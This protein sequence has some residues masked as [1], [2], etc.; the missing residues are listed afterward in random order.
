M[1]KS[2]HALYQHWKAAQ[3]RAGKF[4]G[5]ANHRCD[6]KACRLHTL[7]LFRRAN[8]ALTLNNTRQPLRRD[9]ACIAVCTRTGQPHYCGSGV[10]Q[11][12]VETPG[13]DVVC[14]LTGTVL[15]QSRVALGRYGDVES[16][17]PSTY[18][19]RQVKEMTAEVIFERA[20]QI[21]GRTKFSRPANKRE[22]LAQVLVLV[23][24]IFSKERFEAE[25]QRHHEHNAFIQGEIH[26]YISR[27]NTKQ[28]F[29]DVLHL[30][31]LVARLRQRMEYAMS[32]RL[33]EEPLK[34]LANG[35]ATLVTT[36]W[37]V[38]R[39]RAAAAGG[40]RVATVASLREFVL[41]TLETC[42]T[43]LTVCARD[44]SYEIEIVPL[45]PIMQ[46]LPMTA[47]AQE[48]VLGK[49]KNLARVRKNI[50]SALQ[51][52]I[53]E[54]GVNPEELRL[55]AY[56]FEGLDETAFSGL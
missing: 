50:K 56:E 36:L 42:Q 18:V 9:E 29:P 49:T 6:G 2:M 47:A 40:Q 19:P 34:R 35:Y 37:H 7:C 48:I 32:L 44:R 11:E 17:M 5:T 51:E 10:C 39:T 31:A 4:Y 8:G 16:T 13:G 28:E 3:D 55:V 20:V 41:A 30:A 21:S 52:A 14:R 24:S 12:T 46:I 26:K 15:T 43:G 45:D 53:D 27:C 33:Q 38:L 1:L 23:T 25:H 54:H 22:F